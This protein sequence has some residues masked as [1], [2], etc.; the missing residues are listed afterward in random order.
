MLFLKKLGLAI[1]EFLVYMG[2]GAFIFWLLSL[3]NK[4][5]FYAIGAVAFVVSIMLN[6]YFI[7]KLLK[8]I[9]YNTMINQKLR[10]TEKLWPN[11]NLR[12]N[13]KKT[14]VEIIYEGK[15]ISY[16]LSLEDV[17]M[18]SPEALTRFI[19]EVV[20]IKKAQKEE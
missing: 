6:M 14:F 2:A 8:Q 4:A 20:T 1:L 17:E 3:E 19:D 11:R 16:N 10:A 7:P 15:P 13:P 9:E 18:R 12:L 5:W